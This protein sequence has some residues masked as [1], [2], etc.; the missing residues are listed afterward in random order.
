MFCFNICLRFVE[1][2][3][4]LD[5]YR[6]V[7]DEVFIQKIERLNK[8]K[9]DVEA[10]HINILYISL[11]LLFAQPKTSKNALILC[12]AFRSC[13]RAYSSLWKITPPSSLQSSDGFKFLC[14][15]LEIFCFLFIYLLKHNLKLVDEI[16]GFA[17]DSKPFFNCQILSYFVLLCGF[18]RKQKNFYEAVQQH[19]SF[20]WYQ[21]K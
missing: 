1:S 4:S 14:I 7:Y 16:V 18:T 6:V 20:V 17:L 21:T 9:T 2:Q 11:F 12:I 10:E 19:S 5:E 3:G 8:P 13:K 15:D